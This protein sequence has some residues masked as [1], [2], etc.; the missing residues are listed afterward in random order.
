MTL[1]LSMR[2]ADRTTF[3]QPNSLTTTAEYRI[4]LD[5][6][7][8]QSRGYIYQLG[9][10][11][12]LFLLIESYDLQED[13]F[14][15]TGAFDLPALQFGFAVLG[16]D[17]PLE[18][19]QG[20]N[21]F[22]SYFNEFFPPGLGTYYSAGQKIIYIELYFDPRR[23]FNAYT[24]QLDLLPRSLQSYLETEN[25]ALLNH[26]RLGQT[27]PKMQQ[28][29]QQILDCPFTGDT[30]NVYLEAKILEL[31][32]LKLEP[33]TSG[34]RE[35]ERSPKLKPQ[36]ID[37]IYHARTILRQQFTSPPSLLELSQQVGLNDYKLQLGFKQ[38]FG[39]T[40][41]GY[42]WECRMQE[43]RRLLCS[44]DLTIQVIAT[45]VGY[46]CPSRFTAAFKKRFGVTPTQ[47]LRDR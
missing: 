32:A 22:L 19:S 10:P 24:G 12:G 8:Q 36:D 17:E 1:F 2:N 38:I 28:V 3:I 43:A 9:F 7:K 23:Y 35:L 44:K 25:I 46:A 13:L 37:R 30:R 21:Y 15:E 26:Y 40:M 47:Y 4:T 42:V 20:R 29:L 16:D 5:D 33:I 41:F 31:I 27:T 39:T 45:R 11:S 14:V 34:E 18:L 6:R